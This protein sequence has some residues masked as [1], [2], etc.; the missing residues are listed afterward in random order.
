[1][2]GQGPGQPQRPMPPQGPPSPQQ[3][4]TPYP[5]G[6]G[7]PP[8][9]GQGRSPGPPFPGGPPPAPGANPTTAP[10][11]PWPPRQQ[12][13]PPASPASA[14]SGPGAAPG[15]RLL[16]L[17][18]VAVLVGVGATNAVTA[19]LGYLDNGNVGVLVLGGDP[20]FLAVAQAACGV[21]WV[22]FGLLL[23]TRRRTPWGAALA[24]VGVFG[25]LEA[26]YI[27]G[28][29][30]VHFLGLFAAVVVAALLNL[31]GVRRYCKVGP[32]TR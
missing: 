3:P 20:L 4:R 30:V 32:P 7:Y 22:V 14:A 5:G 24:S 12:T 31:D 6:P 1:M 10:P 9:Q 26:Y 8:G 23:L 27:G 13:A 21:A 2:Y 18:A 19:V 16:V 11:A 29:A 25:V 28:G 17:A 15:S